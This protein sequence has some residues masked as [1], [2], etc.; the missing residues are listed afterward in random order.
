MKL[1][2]NFSSYYLLARVFLVHPSVNK[3]CD[4][5]TSFGFQTLFTGT[6]A[7]NIAYGELPVEVD[8]NAV[9]R[10]A[11]LANA[12]EFI[13]KLPDGYSTN[14]GDR[15]S[16]LSGGQRQRYMQYSPLKYVV[17]SVGNTALWCMLLVQFWTVVVTKK[18]GV[19]P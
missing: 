2:Q 19:I 7:E 6:V 16:S 14:L 10:A 9:K 13:Q 11:Q 8:I 5:H 12:D 3:F 1:F 4:V 17:W 18:I 15:A